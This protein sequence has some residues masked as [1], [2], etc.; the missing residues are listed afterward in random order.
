MFIPRS[1]LF[2][3]VSL[4]H[5][6]N[7]TFMSSRAVLLAFLAAGLLPMSNAEIGFATS[8]GAML[9]AITQ[10]LFGYWADKTGGRYL[11]ALGQ[12]W[13]VGLFLLAA[14][15]AESTGQY[16]LMALPMVLMSLGSGMIHPVGSLHAAESDA[17]RVATHMSY[18]FL[19]GQL[20][21]GLGPAL[22]GMLL[23]MANGVGGPPTVMPLLLLGFLALPSVLLMW[24]NI[25][26]AKAR[27]AQRAQT[28]A[29]A[30]PF[31]L[32]DW[33]LMAFAILIVMVML[34]GLAQPGSADF[35]PLLFQQKG[36]R[37]SEYGFVTSTFWIAAG[38]AGVFFGS[39][40]DRYDQRQVMMWSMLL[41]APAFFLLPF[42]DGIAALM[43]AIVAGGLS[44]GSHSL[45]VVMAQ[46]LMPTSKG[47]ASGMILGLI[48][49]T[50]ALGSLI[51]GRVSDSIGLAATFQLASVAVVLAGFVALALPGRRKS[52]VLAQ[53]LVE[54]AAD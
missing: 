7:D 26:P 50:G 10:P 36:W 23:D 40:A 35:L 52:K 17:T 30:K 37:A 28:P 25:P 12:M 38:L 41:S 42:A 5:F 15:A 32:A 49:G 39:L 2:W 29:S 33:P 53:P 14:L 19:A 9:G 18:F 48:F 51:I 46:E 24:V 11:A 4:G 43:L 1:R 54:P 21:L 20:G 34:R 22:V 27:R 31:S 16:A 45:I 3:A 44:G 6:V 13:L 47:L 8:M